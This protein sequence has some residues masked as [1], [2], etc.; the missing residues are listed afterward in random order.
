MRSQ[1]SLAQHERVTEASASIAAVAP[2]LPRIARER[3]LEDDQAHH[4][5][6]KI[7]PPFKKLTRNIASLSVG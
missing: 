2:A 3:A 7:E 5:V 6:P 1:R 4:I